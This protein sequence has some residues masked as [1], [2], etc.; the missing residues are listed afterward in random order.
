MDASL[1]HTLGATVVEVDQVSF[2]YD[3]GAF[4]PRTNPV[5]DKVSLTAYEGDFI[6]LVG[7]NGGGKTTLLKLILG[8]L[9]P[10]RGSIRVLGRPPREASGW[11]GYVP[12]HADFDRHFP[13]RVEDLVLMGRLHKGPWIRRYRSV[14]REAAQ[15]ALRVVDLENCASRPLGTLSGG[16]RQR[17]LI[18]RALASQPKLLIMD[19]PT[20]GVDSH[21]EQ[22]V[23][24]LLRRINQGE[25]TSQGPTT[26]I[27]VSHDLG[28]I[29][30][31]VNRVACLNVRLV[32]HPTEQITGA[33]IEDLYRGPVHFVKHNH[34]VTN[35]RQ[36]K[37]D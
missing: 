15:E 1:G 35:R 21:V 33:V 31:Y 12:Q 6:G 30:S 29:S 22:D 37:N 20:A 2:W 16:Q 14:D 24:D 34:I 10:F 36:S 5:L 25:V 9:H 8:L 32:C 4:I 11:V 26:I 18:A 13:I 28:F 3:G 19:E 23:Y 17:A 27:L 7:P